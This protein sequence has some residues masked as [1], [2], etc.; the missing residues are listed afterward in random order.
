MILQHRRFM[1]FLFLIEIFVRNIFAIGIE[2]INIPNIPG[3]EEFNEEIQFIFQNEFYFDVY[4]PDEYWK[5]DSSKQDLANEV[6]H[7]AEIL[8]GLDNSKQNQDLA[9]LK[10]LL[11]FYLYNLDQPGS[12]NKAIHQME[13]IGN[14]SN[15][16]YRYIW[17][18]A[19]IQS[20]STESYKAIDNFQYIENRIPEDKIHPRFWYDYAIA[21]SLAF[22]PSKALDCYEKLGKYSD[23]DLQNDKFYIDLRDNFIRASSDD[24]IDKNELFTFYNYENGPG[25]ISRQL[26]I[27]MPLKNSWYPML[28]DYKNHFSA[29]KFSSEPIINEDTVDGISY[30]ITT[31]F[32]HNTDSIL[33]KFNSIAPNVEEI[34]NSEFD[35]MFTVLEISEP[36]KYPHMGGAHGYVV[37]YEKD[38]SNSKTIDIEKPIEMEYE[39]D[40]SPK[41]FH[42]DKNYLRLDGKISYVFLLDSCEFIFEESKK[43]FI[44][45]ITNMVI[46]DN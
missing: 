18:L 10:G 9:L 14:Y 15:P 1:L 8:E 22:M 30:T 28:A 12:L 13:I 29:I 33:S 42:L 35:P 7:F 44:E 36:E 34:R 2:L 24:F 37:I 6:T 26:G 21:S 16:D 5:Y 39:K 20:A 31:F 32:F 27:W 23:Y 25:V 38:I 43:D 11:Y 41:Y 46:E 17:F 4:V 3:F 19:A 40:G 45:F